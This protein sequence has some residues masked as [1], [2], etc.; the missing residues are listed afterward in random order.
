M[1]N[2]KSFDE[3]VNES[4]I[5]KSKIKDVLNRLG[6]ESDEYIWKGDV[7]TATVK[8]PKYKKR[9]E[10]TILWDSGGYTFHDEIVK[11]FK[12][13]KIPHVVKGTKI[14]LK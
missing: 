3:F 12:E 6:I 2:L 7:I 8:K 9:K 5:D 10:K 14:Y 4:K 11:A 13:E 1:R